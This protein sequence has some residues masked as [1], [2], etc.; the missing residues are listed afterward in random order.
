MA[1]TAKAYTPSE[2]IQGP[3]DLWVIGGVPSDANVRLT[4]AS[5]GTPDATT[6]PGSVHLGA[7]QGAITTTV[8]PKLV[9]ITA[10]QFDCPVDA[11]VSEL[12]AKVEGTMAQMEATKL[13]RAVGV[14]AYSTGSGYKQVTFGGVLTVPQ[15]CLALI[16]PSRANPNQY[17]ISVLYVAVATGGFSVALGRAKAADYKASFTGLADVTRTAGKTIGVLYQTLANASGGTP[18]AK[19]TLVAEI[20]QGP[21]DLWLVSPA[22][23]DAAMRVTLD[24]ATLTPDSATHGTSMHLGLTTGAVT[25]KVAPKID[26]I[27]S[28]QFDAPIDAF[29]ATMSASIEAEMSQS[30]M[31]KLARALGV[32]NYTLSAGVFAQCTFGGTNQP[33]AICVAAIG[34]KRSDTTKAVVGC[35]Y[36]V[37][38]AD[39]ITWSASRTKAS[40]YKV[41]FNGLA[42]V[43]RTAGKTVGIYHEMI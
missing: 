21:A 8:K 28:D 23:T 33:P 27:K 36:R 9:A 17:V 32:G 42:D 16:S 25:F 19:S 7:V 5:D 4:L 3:G 43:A 26:F 34:L 6:H 38:A 39:G 35:L 22:P 37:N 29:V 13:Q 40:S 12:D 18:T 24:A 11:Y 31:D 30:S 20:Y 2:I 14:G 41:L 1:G 15:F 10:D